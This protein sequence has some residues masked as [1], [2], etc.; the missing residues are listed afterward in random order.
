MIKF[1]ILGAV[2]RFNYGDL[3]FPIILQQYIE[4][5]IIDKI[6]NYEIK[7]YSLENSDLSNIGAL[8]TKA[9]KEFYRDCNEDKYNYIILGGG[10][11]LPVRI[12]Y[13]YM[14][15]LKESKDVIA[16]NKLISSGFAADVELFLIDHYDL[17]SKFPWIP[18]KNS[19]PINSKI[20][21]NAV[22][23]STLNELGNKE[24]EV[25]RELL[26]KADYLSVR[27]SKTKENL[28]N[29]SIP[30]ELY[31]DSGAIISDIFTKEKLETLANEKLKENLKAYKGYI[32]FQ[33]NLRSTWKKEEIL[34]NEL[35]KIY[36]TYGCPIV[37]LPIGLAE[38]HND[39]K[40][41]KIIYSKLKIPK[42]L[43][44][45]EVNLFDIIFTIA[46]SE[47]F[48]GSSLHG[49]I[50]ALSYGVKHLGINKSIKKLKS[51]LETWD[52]KENDMCIDVEEIYEQFV[53]VEAIDKSKIVEIG[54]NIKNLAYKN[55]EELFQGLFQDFLK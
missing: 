20:V 5:Y 11:L 39:L 12:I 3:L 31:P 15:T 49:N 54:N 55:L 34:I 22:G 1:K 32:C 42:L 13:S 36:D 16:L 30:C 4:K 14:D 7:V 50:T 27:D 10:D 38:N 24:I 52:S 29:L 28:N 23:G 40:A 21:Y 9:M 8:K 53:K 43:L 35:N 37:L 6:N 45:E 19:I 48:I 17:K 18:D 51:Y 47:F 25:V 2:D 26:D 44:L 41:L 33:I 46:N